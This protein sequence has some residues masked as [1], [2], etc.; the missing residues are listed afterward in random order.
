MIPL[1][2]LVPVEEHV[3]HPMMGVPRIVTPLVQMCKLTLD[4]SLGEEEQEE[5]EV[6][7]IQV[8]GRVITMRMKSIF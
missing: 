4:P 6:I 1:S 7:F 2:H 3:L 8:L 5:E